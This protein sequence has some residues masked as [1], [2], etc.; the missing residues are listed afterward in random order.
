MRLKF[1]HMMLLMVIMG[2]CDD[3]VPDTRAFQ[4]E[5][6]REF[7]QS[8]A[9]TEEGYYTF[10]SG[11]GGYTML[12]PVDATLD[13]GYY[14][15]QGDVI[16]NISFANDK[17]EDYNFSSGARI[18]YDSRSVNEHIDINL[19][20]LSRRVSYEGEYDT[21]QQEEKTIYYSK[22]QIDNT[23]Y[24]FGLVKSELN[25]KAVSYVYT[26]PC[27][28]EDEKCIDD[29]SQEEDLIMKMMSSINFN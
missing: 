21:I 13:E 2:G 5:F 10:E 8:T 18:K 11:T 6:T 4:D 15:K 19:K 26:V 28:S 3:N 7:M 16:E 23:Y 1:I 12:F 9:E 24:F 29:I 22:N 17:K 20:S 25:H 14:Y 27:S